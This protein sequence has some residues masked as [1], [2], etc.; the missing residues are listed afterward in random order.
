[1]LESRI[2]VMCVASAIGSQVVLLNTCDVMRVGYLV[3]C[4]PAS[5]ISCGI[6]QKDR[7]NT[8]IV[9]L[10]KYNH[11]VSLLRYRRGEETIQM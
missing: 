7:I 5:K 9:H 10:A 4:F 3:Y 1:M 8:L 2:S 6:D 11:E